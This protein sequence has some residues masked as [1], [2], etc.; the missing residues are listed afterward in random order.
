MLL[1]HKL[2]Y[3]LPLEKSCQIEGEINGTLAWLLLASCLCGVNQRY[4][5]AKHEAY[6]MHT[7]FKSLVAAHWRNKAK[8]LTL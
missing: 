4:Q 2:D 5:P 7:L 8:P 1:V 6:K 3:V